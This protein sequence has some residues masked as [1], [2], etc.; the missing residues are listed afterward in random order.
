MRFLRIVGFVF[1][2]ALAAN[3]QQAKLTGNITD[4]HG[5]VIPDA[6]V[7]FS[8][9]E[10]RLFQ[11]KTNDEGI[12]SVELPS[13]LYQIVVSRQPFTKFVIADYWVPQH[14][15]MKLDVSLRCID[16]KLIE[17]PIVEPSLVEL[18]EPETKISNQ[19]LNRRLEKLPDPRTNNKKEKKDN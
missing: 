9:G 15:S 10:G 3:A 8:G 12:Y 14:G 5:A 7:E 19:I 2:L 6:R 1:L 11:G 4:E 17:C 16:C 18:N 13:G